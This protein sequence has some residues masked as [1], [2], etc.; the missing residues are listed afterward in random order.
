[1]DYALRLQSQLRN[2]LESEGVQSATSQLDHALTYM[3]WTWQ[4]TG[5]DLSYAWDAELW[6]RFKEAIWKDD[7]AIFWNK[8]LNRIQYSESKH[9]F[10]AV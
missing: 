10:C 2:G 6:V 5:I 1:M 7:P 8:L 4:W 3:E 9:M